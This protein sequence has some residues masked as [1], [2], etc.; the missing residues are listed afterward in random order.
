MCYHTAQTEKNV[1]KISYQWDL[2]E[3]AIEGDIPSYYH[4]NGFERAEVLLITQ[5]QPALIQKAR[6][7]IIPPYIENATEYWKKVGGGALNTRI[8][9]VFKN[10]TP[11]WKK[12]A[13]LSQKCIVLLT[14]LYKVDSSNGIKKPMYIQKKDKTM[15]GVLGCYSKNNNNELSTSILTTKADSFFS[16][17]T[18]MP[19]MIA[20]KEIPYY[21]RLTNEDAISAELQSKT[22]YA[23]YEKYHVS[24]DVINAHK[25]SNRQNI[26]DLHQYPS[27]F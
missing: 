3:M 12:E 21:F 13:I 14:G 1:K 6:W 17:H 15:F 10:E 23:D 2:R 26:T 24:T 18:R 8:E 9:S 11:E 25:K 19:F 7:S 22:T 16:F 5:E 27:L 20:S 4:L